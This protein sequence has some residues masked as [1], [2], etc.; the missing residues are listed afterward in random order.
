MVLLPA[1]PE[2]DTQGCAT[3]QTSAIG[4]FEGSVFYAPMV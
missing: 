1:N 4:I 3:Q 2:L